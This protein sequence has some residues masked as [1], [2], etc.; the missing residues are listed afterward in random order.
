MGRIVEYKIVVHPKASDT[1]AEVS[2]FLARGWELY[3]ELQPYFPSRSS[4]GRSDAAFAQAMVRRE[5]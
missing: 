4:V 2:S 1:A 3:G 5:N